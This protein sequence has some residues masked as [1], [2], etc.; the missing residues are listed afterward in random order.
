MKKTLKE[1]FAEIG[2]FGSDI[3]QND[4]GGTHTYL[5]TYDKLF[6]PFQNGCSFLEIGLAGGDSIK[7]WDEYFDNSKIVGC[8]LSIIFER[9]QYKNEVELISCNATDAKILTEL[10][11]KTFDIIID[12]G[13][14]MTQDQI[15]TFNL[16]K[17]RMNKGAVYIIEDI[18]ALDI[19]RS[20]YEGLHSNCEIIDMRDNGRFDNAL[21]IYK[22]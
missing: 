17:S 4:K 3:G 22:F 15:T 18:L 13:S 21:I 9:L 20:K 8:D 11:E 1:I 19:E 6:A 5:E 10:R 2:H 7:L 14:H 16:L 12:D